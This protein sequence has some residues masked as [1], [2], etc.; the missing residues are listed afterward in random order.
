[1]VVHIV[2]L[3][4]GVVNGR[5]GGLAATAARAAAAP[6]GPGRFAP[7]VHVIPIRA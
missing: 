7:V 1:M 4:D 3:D 2:Y 5:Y 6:P